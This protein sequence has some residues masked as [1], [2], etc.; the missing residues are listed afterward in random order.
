MTAVTAA[1]TS[2]GAPAPASGSTKPTGRPAAEQARTASKYPPAVSPSQGVDCTSENGGRSRTAAAEPASAAASPAT[3]V[4]AVIPARSVRM[5][6]LVVPARQASSADP[7]AAV[8]ATASGA[9]PLAAAGAG[10]AQTAATSGSASASRQASVTSPVAVTRRSPP[11]LSSTHG[12]AAA[13][14]SSGAAQESVTSC[15]GTRP[16]SVKLAGARS[17]APR[18]RP[19]D[20]LAVPA[21]RSTAAPARSSTSSARGRADTDSA[22]LERRQGGV[23]Q[24]ERLTLG[25]GLEAQAALLDDDRPDVAHAPVLP[26]PVPRAPSSARRASSSHTTSR[27]TVIGAS[28][29]AQAGASRPGEKR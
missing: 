29:R 23:E 14:A 15:S 9:S 1:A 16:A 18:T 11:P 21:T 12:A 27:T 24:S 26:M 28:P 22:R 8:W 3:A 5:T 7:R 20:S 25:E 10:G 13:A 17:S 2:V 4:A 19:A 6:C